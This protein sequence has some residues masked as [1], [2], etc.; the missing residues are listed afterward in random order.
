MYRR[1]QIL[2]ADASTLRTKSIVAVEIHLDLLKPVSKR[3]LERFL[4][5]LPQ[6]ID[7]NL[8]LRGVSVHDRTLLTCLVAQ[9]PDK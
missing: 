9:I 6:N 4:K 5:C 1:D 7:S 2:V 3:E 8:D